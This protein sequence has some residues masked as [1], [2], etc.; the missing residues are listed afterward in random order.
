M[1]NE[2]TI[3]YENKNLSVLDKP[4]GLMVHPDGSNESRFLTDWVMEKYPETEK[5]GESLK[6]RSGEKV[7]R[8]GIVHRLDKETSGVL[9]IA[10]TEEGFYS[11]KEQF[12]N[13]EVKKT[14]H[15]FVYGYVKKERDRIERPIGKSSKDFRLWSAQ[16]GARG[17]L[18]EASTDYS[19]AQRSDEVSF[20]NISPLTGR[21]HQIRV[22]M[23]AI[24]HP[25]VCDTLYAPKRESL[26]GFNRLALHAS[27]ISF[28]DT[29]GKEH[30]I[31][32]PFPEDFNFAIEVFK[33]R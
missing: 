33:T 8:P 13:R 12:K 29:E 23:K 2:P 17:K 31:R 1:E 3:L 7:K 25:I 27:E 16:R 11:L 10:R 4:A 26:L 6:L 9:L 20:L 28:K 32:A 21:T 22:H 19:V 5:I 30:F 24:N 15:A 18:R 14:Y